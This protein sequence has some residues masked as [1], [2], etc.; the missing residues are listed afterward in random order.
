MKNDHECTKVKTSLEIMGFINYKIYVYEKISYSVIK[1]K[2]K[3]KKA[4]KIFLYLKNLFTKLRN[5][6]V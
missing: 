1:V 4:I 3:A 5:K 2:K 6:N